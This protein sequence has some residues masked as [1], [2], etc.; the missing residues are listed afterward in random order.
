MLL[1]DDLRA[2]LG[3]SRPALARKP[4]C[5]GSHAEPVWWV[6]RYLPLMLAA[7]SILLKPRKPVLRVRATLTMSVQRLARLADFHPIPCD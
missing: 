5:I 1:W 6:P 2:A 4:S 7:G 3:S